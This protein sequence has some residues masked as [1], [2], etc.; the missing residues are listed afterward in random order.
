MFLRATLLLSAWFVS[1]TVI[2]Q[3]DLTATVSDFVC[4]EPGTYSFRLQITGS[5][6][7]VRFPDHDFELSL[8]VDERFTALSTFGAFTVALVSGEGE[9]ECTTTFTIAPPEGCEGDPDTGGHDCWVHVEYDDP[10]CNVPQTLTAT[11][12]GTAPF[13][14]S[15]STGD[16][17]ATITEVDATQDYGVTVTDAAGCTASAHV[18][19]FEHVAGLFVHVQ[20]SGDACAGEQPQLTAEV[21]P[22]SDGPFTYRW[23]NGDTTRTIDALIDTDY[24]VTVTDTT[25][26]SGEGFGYFSS[27]YGGTY[28][29]IV[30]PNVIGC[31]GEAVEL[32]IADPNPNFVYIWVRGADTLTGTSITT[33]QGGFYDVTGFDPAVPGC[34]DF[35]YV[36]V[37]N[38]AA[39]TD[40]LLLLADHGECGE[41]RCYYIVSLNGDFHLTDE[42]ISWTRDGAPLNVGHGSVFCPDGPGEY[43]ATISGPCDTATL[44]LSVPDTVVCSEFC[45]D[46]IMDQ[47]EDCAAD[48]TTI[49]YAHIPVLLTNVETGVTY[50]TFPGPDGTF[51]VNIPVGKYELST[52]GD[53]MDLSTDCEVPEPS[54]TVTE[55][56]PDNMV[57]Y[58]LPAG[59]VSE[60]A[61]PTTSLAP[62]AVRPVDLRVFPNPTAG[63]LS[64]DFRGLTTGPTDDLTLY[65]GLGRRVATTTLAQLTTPWRPDNL[66]S[67]MYRLLL[68]G[69]DGRLKG[70]ATI[71]VR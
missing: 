58:G 65:D 27:S 25:G 29:N 69:A 53:F 20:A 48:E 55:S 13:R 1:L 30:G 39:A 3:C 38:L 41:A 16:T 24:T 8:P 62:T 47:D 31:D 64:F 9:E 33:D 21:F 22:E 46:I 52:V 26:C 35:G 43:E 32:S 4:D 49:E 40:D 2:A 54:M 68:T 5:G 42:Q 18:G 6:E 57:V 66:R 61:E 12:A 15:W 34:R 37:Q 51:C 70:G 36:Q 19:S 7:T 10:V 71:V 67:G 60:E 45:S 50:L 17:T 23:S 11:A 28:L 14:Y 56:M 44:S 63:E 59:S